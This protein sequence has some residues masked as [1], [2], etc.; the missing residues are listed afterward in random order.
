[1]VPRVWPRRDGPAGTDTERL[2]V[3]EGGGGDAGNGADLLQKA[4]VERSRPFRGVAVGRRGGDQ[5]MLSIEAGIDRV[6]AAER[7][8]EQRRGHEHE[9]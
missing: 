5:H 7:P 4:R 2:V 1:V 3:R 9:H 6:Q 8:R